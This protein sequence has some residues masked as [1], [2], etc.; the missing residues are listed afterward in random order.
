M[1]TLSLFNFK[2]N[3]DIFIS[4]KQ[5]KTYINENFFK[6]SFMIKKPIARDN[7]TFYFILPAIL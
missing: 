4:A 2:N 6:S 3:E 7:D 5:A 1:I